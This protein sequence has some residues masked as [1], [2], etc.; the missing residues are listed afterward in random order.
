MYKHLVII[1]AIIATLGLASVA[2]ANPLYIAPAIGEVSATAAGKERVVWVDDRLAVLNSAGK[3]LPGF[4]VAPSG[5]ALSTSPV[6]ADLDGN[7]VKEIAIL[8]HDTV[9]GAGVIYVYNGAGTLLHTLTLATQLPQETTF[10]DAVALPGSGSVEKIVV[11]TNEGNVYQFELINNA[12]T[13]TLLFQTTGSVNVTTNKTGSEIYVS[14]PSSADVK[15]Y[16]KTGATWT[17]KSVVNVSGQIRFSAFDA[18]KNRWYGS[19]V[20]GK[21]VAVDMQ[22]K[23]IVSGW[24]VN[25][26]VL[27]GAPVIA[28]VDTTNPGNEIVGVL[29][30]GQRKVL[31]ENGAAVATTLK[32]RSFVNRGGDVAGQGNVFTWTTTNV[33]QVLSTTKNIIGTYYSRLNL[34]DIQHVIS[35]TVTNLAFGAPVY[36]ADATI[37]V[38][39]SA[40]GG[41]AIAS[42]DYYIVD[43]N[44][45]ESSRYTLAAADGSFDSASEA[46]AG[47]ITITDWNADEAPYT[48]KV[49][50]T[51]VL[52]NVSIPV[53][54]EFTIAD[55]TDSDDTTKGFGGGVKTDVVW[56][57]TKLMLNSTGLTNGGGRFVSRILDAGADTV[58]NKL[59]WI[60]LYPYGKPLPASAQKEVG[61][62]TGN[63]DM[64]GN[65][66]LYHFEDLTDASGK[67][68]A[69]VWQGV[70]QISDDGVYGAT[71]SFN[72]GYVKAGSSDDFKIA[73]TITVEAWVNPSDSSSYKTILARDGSYYLALNELKPAVFFNG[74]STQWQ[75]AT[76]ALPLNT[77][78]HVAATYDGT[79]IKIFVN[80]VL[81][82][83]IAITGTIATPAAKELWIGNRPEN[84]SSYRF[85]GQ[86]DEVAIFNRTLTPG[87]IFAHYR[88]GTFKALFQVR[89]C[90]ESNCADAE[91]VG[92]D[93]TE[94]SY[95]S[96]LN[97]NTIGLPNIT[98]PAAT[99][100]RYFQYQVELQTKLKT[101]GP[102]FASITI[103]PGHIVSG[104][105]VTPPANSLI[106][107]TDDDN[108]SQGFGGGAA[109]G[110]VWNANRRALELTDAA[111]VNGSGTFESR[112]INAG[113][114]VA[115]QNLAWKPL[116][117]YGKE[118][119]GNQA[120]ETQYSKNNVDMRANELLLHLN[121]ATGVPGLKNKALSLAGTEDHL[122]AGAGANLAISGPITL[123][124][125]VNPT[126]TGVYR[127]V[128][129]RNSSYYLALT[130][131]KPAVYFDGLNKPGWH[132]A[133]TAL[134][135]NKWSHVVGVYDGANVKI[136]INGVL[137]KTITDVSGT[138]SVAANK[139]LWLGSRAELG[140]GFKGLI[141]EAAVYSRAL[142]AA[143]VVSR[144]Q[145]LALK[146]KFQVRACASA[147]CAGA[148]YVGPDGTAATYFEDGPGAN[149]P[150][151]NF[152]AT[153]NGQYIQYKAVFET[154]DPALTPSLAS[155]KL[156]PPH[157]TP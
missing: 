113:A 118:L 82:R 108:S 91:F 42:V 54:E 93:G 1:S 20:D 86:M 83:S 144:Y 13:K 142:D 72:P 148:Q 134:A 157:N 99:S 112:V 37:S 126:G 50:A 120:K 76:T 110:V 88:R 153:L 36:G 39:A 5:F 30:N 136:Y 10:Y 46:V 25:F 60:P 12:I 61:Y 78:S 87:E 111:K 65:V 96:E 52:G 53:T 140:Y 154:I 95:Y 151:Q 48:V 143:E 84:L 116:A 90:A 34:P 19:S 94:N 122:N 29:S 141:D 81:N 101:F 24:P 31:K 70:G 17:Q 71:A 139:E 100:K 129:A 47:T 28:D 79:T 21:L 131:L 105:I 145:R 149:L 33:G 16:G 119:P 75:Q 130:N 123:E 114:S 8:G 103:G 152:A 35:P 68:H 32:S 117:A 3:L 57:S 49:V 137:D 89:A 147:N 146:L 22:T 58:W 64:A 150:V 104:E 43:K 18:V 80:G 109:A 2:K 63:V 23:T 102:E 107:Q 40:A 69:G 4:P 73:K 6:L 124:A 11:S 138:I 156:G 115:W 85:A 38:T 7:G 44:N 92:P 128:M 67:N 98:I 106:D 133:N 121:E 56:N 27:A 77:W 97:N 59:S 135:L 127:T 132:I 15:V 155:V 9:T 14:S 66:L 62:N 74:V 26:G 51:D 45:I 41:S 125:W 55:Q